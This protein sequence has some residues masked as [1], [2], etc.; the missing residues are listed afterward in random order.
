MPRWR[1]RVAG[2]IGG[3][4][5]ISPKHQVF[6]EAY[7]RTWNATDAYQE[8]YP[9][10]NRA[11]ARANGAT[12]LANTSIAEVISSRIADR[13]MGKDEVLDR[14]AGQARGSMGDFAKVNEQGQPYF[15]LAAA[16]E[17]HKLGLIKKLK[18][19]TRSFQETY[20]DLEEEDFAKRDVTETN[21]EFELY[22]A[23]SALTLIGRHH[24]IF[25]D[26]VDV[27][28]SGNVGFNADEAA[29]A[30]KELKEFDEQR[31][32]G[33]SAAATD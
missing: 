4:V 3:D 14:L 13:A 25:K 10:A 19:K 15:D 12:L 1:V 27:N 7:L 21:F 18:V 23:Q 8:A 26:K 9:K 5:A 6:V 31:S 16:Q 33:D 17:A 24:G 32:R 30:E 2:A 11:T 29:R 28:V 20:Y 22:D